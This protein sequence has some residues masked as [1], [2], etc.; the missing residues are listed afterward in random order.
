[1]KKITFL[2]FFLFAVSA[3]AQ[4][5]EFKFSKDGFTDYVVTA[6]VGK[7]QAELYKKT[8]DWVAVTYKNPKEVIK[9]QIEND[10]IRIEGS[11]KAL[12]VLN[13]LGKTYYDATYQIEISFKDGKYKFDVI[14]VRY[15]TTP[16]QYSPGGWGEFGLANT[17][18]YYNKKGQIR[19]AFKYIPETL[20]D[21]FN[22]LNLE[23]KDFLMS[24]QIPSKKNEW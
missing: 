10:Y 19:S 16:S 20:P 11:S 21:Y 24:D 1:M 23:L 8:L 3:I 9:A 17:E 2:L 5:T 6:C 14:E 12:I 4:E 18:G 22:T 13:I 7:T 15:Y